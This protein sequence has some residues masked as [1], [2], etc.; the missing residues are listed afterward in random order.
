MNSKNKPLNDSYRNVLFTTMLLSIIALSSTTLLP[1]ADAFSTDNH[2]DITSRALSFLKSAVIDDLNKQHEYVDY[3]FQFQ[4]KYHFDNC[5]FKGATETINEHYR[6]AIP[7]LN[8]NNFDL[9]E[10]TLLFGRVLHPAQDF[11]SH[12]NWVESGQEAIL[13]HGYRHWNILNPLC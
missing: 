11:Y 6:K 13:D 5:E 1:V 3:H 10:S 9:D 12:S 8:P 4:N 7:T 2:D